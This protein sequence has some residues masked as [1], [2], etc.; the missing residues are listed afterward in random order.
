MVASSVEKIFE[1]DGHVG[2]A[3]SGLTADARMLVEHAR[4]D[5]QHH[6]F[7]YNEPIKIE[8]LTQAIYDLSLRFG[9]GTGGGTLIMGRPFGV[10]LLIAG[11]DELGAHL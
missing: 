5:A 2:C 11:V 4:V 3:V 9:E 10:A 6:T 1:I 7:V 8:S